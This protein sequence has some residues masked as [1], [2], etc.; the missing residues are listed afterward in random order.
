LRDLFIRDFYLRNGI[1]PLDGLSCE[2]SKSFKERLASLSPEEQRVAKRKFRKI[3]RKIE[4]EYRSQSSY[5]GTKPNSATKL[6]RRK[7]V[8]QYIIRKLND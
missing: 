8:H 6:R 7:L 1:V 5:N 2:D 4:K 3:V